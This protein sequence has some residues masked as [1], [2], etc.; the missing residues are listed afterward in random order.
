M[1]STARATL[2]VLLLVGLSHAPLHAAHVKVFLIGGQSNAAGS[3]LNTEYPALYQTP[4]AD[5]E[6][7]AGG[8]LAADS[9][10]H[11]HRRFRSAGVSGRAAL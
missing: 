4:Q 8:R 5:V 6:F 3:G 2:W 10:Q 11:D 1:K 9:F 7:W